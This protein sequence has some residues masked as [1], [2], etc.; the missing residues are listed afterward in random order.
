M[1]VYIITNTK[2]GKK[3]IGKTKNKIEERF[4]THLYLSSI[5]V[6]T[7]LYNAIRKYGKEYFCCCLLEQVEG[8]IEI[9]NEREKYWISYYE[10]LQQGYNMT[11][12]GDGGDTS[13]SEKYIEYMEKRGEQISGENN[14]FYGKKHKEETKKIISE[15]MKG[16]THKKETKEIL[17]IKNT[18]KKMSEESI[19]KGIEKRSETWRITTPYNE[20]IIIKNLSKFCKENGLDQ[21]NMSKV[22][23]GIYK[24]SKGFKCEK[25]LL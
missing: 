3:Y 24:T 21:R 11:L 23:A 17:S 20:I 7:K 12:G 1:Y 16:R 13:F 25:V 15:K 2:N 8:N 4:K 19:K 14:P 22:A 10:T 9:L 6:E 18:G 5:G